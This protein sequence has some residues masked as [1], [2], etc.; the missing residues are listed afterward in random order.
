MIHFSQRRYIHLSKAQAIYSCKPP[1]GL[2]T[3]GSTNILPVIYKKPFS[4]TPVRYFVAFIKFMLSSR[5]FVSLYLASLQ[6]TVVMVMDKK[7]SCASTMAGGIRGLSN[8]SKAMQD[9]D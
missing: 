5:C 7:C 6:I 9:S 4:F 3:S 2:L 1:P 8:E